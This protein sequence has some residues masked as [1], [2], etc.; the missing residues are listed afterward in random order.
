[1]VVARRPARRS[2]R[3]SSRSPSAAAD[4]PKLDAAQVLSRL[5]EHHRSVI[6]PAMFERLSFDHVREVEYH[7]HVDRATNVIR[8]TQTVCFFSHDRNPEMTLVIGFKPADGERLGAWIAHVVRPQDVT[9]SSGKGI[10]GFTANQ[11][12]V[13]AALGSGFESLSNTTVDDRAAVGMGAASA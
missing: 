9:T 10:L 12:I 5:N 4:G 1:M 8:V 11:D 3:R 2:P 6:F 7:F 13:D